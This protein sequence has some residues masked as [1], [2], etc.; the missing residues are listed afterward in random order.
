MGSPS[1]QIIGAG[2]GYERLASLGRPP[3][4]AASLGIWPKRCEELALALIDVAD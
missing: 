4:A 1:A 2:A 3:Q